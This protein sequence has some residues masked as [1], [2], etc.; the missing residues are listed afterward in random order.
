MAEL[1][2]QGISEDDLREIAMVDLAYDVLKEHGE[3]MLFHDLLQEIVKL[4]GF[5][6]EETKEYIAQLY[7]EIN[8]DGRFVCVGKGLWGLK[9]WYPVEQT[10]DSAVAANVKDDLEE[11]LE[12]EILMDEDGLELDEGIVDDPD[13]EGLYGDEIDAPDDTEIDELDEDDL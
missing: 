11:E 10:T 6:E 12:E 5:T 3:A 13:Y 2:K 1:A 7:T 8:I 9:Q 4:K